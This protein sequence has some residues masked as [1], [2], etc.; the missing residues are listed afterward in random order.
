MNLENIQAAEPEAV[1]KFVKAANPEELGSLIEK[2]TTHQIKSVITWI[3]KR[4]D[5]DWKKK[6]H[7]VTLSLNDREQLQAV[8]QSLSIDQIGHLINHTFQTEDKHHWK[9][10][11]LLMNLRFDIFSTFLFNA[12]EQ[13]LVLLQHEGVTEP[14]Q[15]QLTLL[16]HEFSKQLEEIEEEIDAF[17]EDIDYL[18]VELLDREDVIEL[19]FNIKA[20]ADFFEQLFHNANKTL[21]VAWN[22]NRTDLIE[23]LNNVKDSCQ[24]YR[25]YGIGTPRTENAEPTGLYSELEDVLFEEFGD[26]QDTTDREALRDDEPATEALAK[27]S[28]WDLQDYWE[29][30][31]LTSIKTQ[32][33]LNASRSKHN[34]N[35]RTA[36]NEKYFNEIR[37]NLEKLGLKTVLD[38]KIASI[39]SKKSLQQYIQLQHE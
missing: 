31:L 22:T 39:F 33:E 5:S 16:C 8:A 11:P 12:S 26:P 36:L 29:I 9:L 24:K 14:V 23:T 35:E 4:H 20:F 17:C 30:G 25:I 32:K 21:A 27:F 6:I 7:R 38:L 2:M 34:D 37:H 19:K 15:H 1:K 3:D 18:D 13:E 10:S 28:V